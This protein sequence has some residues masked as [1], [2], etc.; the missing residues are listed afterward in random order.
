MGK[1]NLELAIKSFPHVDFQVSWKP[2]FLNPYLPE[3]GIPLDLYMQQKYG[4]SGRDLSAAAQY[5]RQAGARVGIKFLEASQRKVYPTLRSHLLTEFVGQQAG[6]QAQNDVVEQLFNA[7]FEKGENINSVPF[8]LSIAKNVGVDK[9][10]ELRAYLESKEGRK[11][12][13]SQDDDAKTRGIHGVPFF[14]ISRPNGRKRLTLSGGQPSE[15]FVEVFEELG[16]S[17]Q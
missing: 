11:L 9:E 5:L 6:L 12:I 13:E 10:D 15:A 1:R 16:F 8:L 3:E 14:T 17:K 2:F 4:R 7:Y